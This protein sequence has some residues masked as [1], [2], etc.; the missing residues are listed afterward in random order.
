[1]HEIKQQN[2][3]NGFLLILPP[4]WRLV[5]PFALIREVA[6]S[7]SC[8]FTFSSGR[9]GPKGALNGES[10][11]KGELGFQEQFWQSKDACDCGC[12]MRGLHHLFIVF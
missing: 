6:P 5:K 8:S 1:M 12:E 10:S 11:S 2:I 9:N 4:M 3:K 7:S